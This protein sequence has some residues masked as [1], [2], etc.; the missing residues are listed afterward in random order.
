IRCKTV[1]TLPLTLRVHRG[2]AP[3]LTFCFFLFNDK[4][5]ARPAGH[6]QL[7]GTAKKTLGGNA[8]QKPNR[9]TFPNDLTIKKALQQKVAELPLN[10]LISAVPKSAA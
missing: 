8:E 9:N 6:D 10:T 5:K 1:V 7:A 4:K 2:A 3:V